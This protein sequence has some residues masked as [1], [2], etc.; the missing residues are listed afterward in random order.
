[1]TNKI[2]YKNRDNLGAG[3]VVTISLSA[4]AEWVSALVLAS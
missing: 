1:M 3:P 2:Q 4:V